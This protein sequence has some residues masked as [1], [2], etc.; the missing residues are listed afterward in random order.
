MEGGDSVNLDQLSSSVDTEE[1]NICQ[2]NSETNAETN[3]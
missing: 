1:E 3:E 2:A